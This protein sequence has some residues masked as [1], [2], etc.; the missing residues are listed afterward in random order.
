MSTQN[1]GRPEPCAVVIFGARGDLTRRKLVPALYNLMC[2]GWLPENLAIVGVGRRPED[3]E[4]FKESLRAGV[5]KH[6]R[7][8]LD[9]DA[10]NRLER[11]ISYIEVD[12]SDPSSMQTLVAHLD[13]L[14]ETLGTAGNRVFYLAVPP[15]AFEE[16]VLA[17]GQAGLHR[18]DQGWSRLV[19]EKPIGH[20]L[21]TAAE[22]ND[23]LNSVFEEQEVF[24]IDHYLGKETVQN[25]L[26]FR[27]ANAVWEP[28]WNHKYIDHVQITVA[29]S[30]GVEGRGRY[31][32]EAG[33]ARDMMQNHMFQLLC[34]T[35]MEP[36]ATLAPDAIRD[37]KVK[38]LQALRPVAPADVH[39]TTVRAQYSAGAV[40]GQ[41][42]AGYKEEAH[43]AA[44]SRTETFVGA[45]IHIDNWRWADVPFYLRA[46]KRMPTRLTEIALEF[47]HVP[48]RLFPFAPHANRLILRIQ[49]DE[50]ITFR[51]DAKVPGGGR[52][53]QVSMDFRYHGS[54]DTQPPEAY[55][56]LLLD[57]MLGDSTL[58]IRRDEVE[59]SWRYIDRLREGWLLEDDGEP[60]P[61][62]TSGTWGPAEADLMLARDGRKWRRPTIEE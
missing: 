55:E 57:A 58:F 29:E 37:E 33:T 5:A 39:E 27:F 41:P 3:S 26:V 38:V 1:S 2:D 8:S 47:R 50:G 25:L 15:S 17:L 32:E 42:V 36:P 14:D 28:L 48:H 40:T 20:D 10:W 35:A 22:L 11:G 52:A 12:T 7:R 59:A 34:L 30:I 13:H 9:A 53:R 44:G 61:E 6:S 21:P 31:Y 46:G 62:Y 51:F 54:F 49:P 24:R 16:I 18:P 60:L 43:V 45:R 56:R 23:C 19:V 4:A